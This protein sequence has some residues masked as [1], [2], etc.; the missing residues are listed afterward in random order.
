MLA[1]HRQPLTVGVGGRPDDVG[2]PPDQDRAGGD[3]GAWRDQR[4]LAQDAAITEPG[5]GHE[6]RAVADLA[7]V[8]D[9][10]PDDRGAVTED[11]A[12]AAGCEDWQLAD[13][14]QALAALLSSTC[15]AC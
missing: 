1:Q 7:Q 2:R 6:D 13:V 10:R 8:A 14:K 5:T 15:H 11:G 9:G 12:L 3:H 4:A